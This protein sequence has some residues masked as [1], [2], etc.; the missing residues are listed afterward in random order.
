[1]L[2]LTVRLVVQL[3]RIWLR[4]TIGDSAAVLLKTLYRLDARLD[5]G[6][7][8][9]ASDSARA[10]QVRKARRCVLS[11]VAVPAAHGGRVLKAASR[12]HDCRLV[13]EVLGQLAQR[14]A[15]VETV[16]VYIRLSGEHIFS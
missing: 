6:T 11:G 7:D 5:V 9:V 1:M 10:L 4:A 13:R 3:I 12:S 8:I 16:F 2:A 14:L 15:L